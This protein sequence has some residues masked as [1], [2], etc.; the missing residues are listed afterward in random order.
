MGGSSLLYLS[1]W[2]I[3]PVSLTLLGE[4]A[5]LAPVYVLA[6]RLA[7]LERNVAAVL[8]DNGLALFNRV[9]A[10]HISWDS[11]TYVPLD[12]SW[13][14][15]ALLLGNILAQL[16]RNVVAH[17]PW[18]VLAFL[19]WNAHANRATNLLWYILALLGLDVLANVSLD[20]LAFFLRYVNL[21]ISALNCWYVFTLLSGDSFWN[22]GG[23]LPRN[24]GTL[25]LEHVLA[26]L[27]LFGLLEGFQHPTALLDR[28]RDALLL[29]HSLGDNL[30]LGLGFVYTDIV[31]RH[32]FNLSWDNSA[33]LFGNLL[34]GLCGYL[35]ALLTGNLATFLSW[36]LH[37][38]LRTGALT[39][40]TAATWGSGLARS[41]QRGNGD[42]N[43]RGDRGAIRVVIS[44]PS[45]MSERGDRGSV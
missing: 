16:F 29:G 6:F 45:E 12:L 24:I 42:G 21:D 32:L 9:A 39:G 20:S 33:G 26:D 11:L 27:L 41:G 31:V 34:A 44:L 10:T 5:F 3:H 36:L 2:P 28:G 23:N 18:D 22:L 17:L 19:F 25:L 1:L 37:V 4:C 40:S 7:V 38:F 15:S 14:L 8:A 35:T 13:N 43:G 30:A